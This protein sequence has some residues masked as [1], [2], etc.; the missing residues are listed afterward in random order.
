MALV[1]PRLFSVAGLLLLGSLLLLAEGCLSPTSRPLYYQ[2]AALPHEQ[3]ATQILTS[4]KADSLARPQSREARLLHKFYLATHGQSAWIDKRGISLAAWQLV[5][6]LENSSQDGLPPERYAPNKL[7]KQLQPPEDEH[8]AYLGWPPARVA[9]VDI[10]LSRAFFRFSGDH[11][12]GQ[13]RSWRSRSDW[14]R[15]SGDVGPVQLLEL[16]LELDAMPSALR[17]VQSQQT[18]YLRLRQALGRYRELKA[19]GGWGSIDSGATLRLGETEPRVPQLRK[20]LWLEGDLS[21][22]EGAGDRYELELQQGLKQFQRRHGLSADGTLGPMS[23]Q[24]LNAP[25]EVRIDQILRNMERWRWEDNRPGQMQIRVNLA[26]FSLEVTDGQKSLFRMP[27]VIGR[28]ERATPLFASQ[29]EALVFAPYWYVPPTLLREALPRIIADPAYLG[30]NHYEV[31]DPGGNLLRVGRDFGRSWQQG[32]VQ[33]SLR[34]QPGP[35]NPMGDVKFLLPN[36]WSIYLHD[37]PQKQLFNRTERAF[38]SGCIRLSQPQKLAKWLLEAGNWERAEID[39]L[40]DSN[41][42][43]MIRLEKPIDLSIGYWTAWVDD[44]G[45]VNFRDDIYGRDQQ[46]A[47]ELRQSP[48]HLARAQSD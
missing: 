43:R 14:H 27:V 5:D 16:A 18:G 22:V 31:L 48:L 35:W 37:T 10:A 4:V 6:F 3:I 41:S 25:V 44:A 24:A 23:L 15:I 33:A 30:R 32:E 45:R 2:Q 17:G 29:L 40:F 20:R 13:E 36:R 39:D 38:S 26:A 1:F 7:R 34:Q 42:T 46:L 9:E 21:G 47:R 11:L 19:L 12:F 8:E 28:Q